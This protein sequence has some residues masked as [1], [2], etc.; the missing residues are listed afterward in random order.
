MDVFSEVEKFYSSYQ[1]EKKIVGESVLSRPIFAMKVG[2]GKPCILSQYGIHGREWVTSLLALGHLCLGLAKGSAWVL[3]LVDPDGALLS[4]RGLCSVP[5]ERKNY[6]LKL[7][8]TSDF[9]LW[10]A[11]A[12]GVDL[13]VN[14]DAR[15]GTGISNVRAPA[16]E[17][18]IGEFP[19]SAPETRALRDFTLWA[20]PN[21]TV[22]WHTKGEVIYWEFHQPFRRKRRDKR[23]AEILSDAT[24]YPLASSKG[25]AGGY[26]DWCVEKLCLPAFTVE[27]GRDRL[28][29]PLGREAVF[30]I[31]MKNSE[32]LRRLT[33]GIR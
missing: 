2:T 18:Y 14:F 1:G 25:S 13:N 24:G 6:L 11:N 17:N 21:A 4:Q 22:S 9:S 19:F 33:E 10:K 31:F 5:E 8:G 28:P 15:W 16:P 7:N 30:E 32:A 27:V 12:D 29:H 23:L 26:K 3:P 20:E